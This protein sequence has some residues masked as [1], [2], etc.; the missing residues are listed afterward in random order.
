MQK[1]GDFIQLIKTSGGYNAIEYQNGGA[2]V[3]IS[4]ETL[5]RWTSEYVNLYSNGEEVIKVDWESDKPFFMYST[6]VSCNLQKCYIR[7]QELQT[8]PGTYTIQSGITSFHP[9]STFNKSVKLSKLFNDKEKIGNELYREEGSS[10]LY[11]SLG[12]INYIYLNIAFLSQ[13]MVQESNNES[14]EVSIRR[15]LQAIC[16]GVNKALGSINDLQVISDT[17]GIAETLTIIDYEQKRI[18]GLTSCKNIAKLQAQGLGSM[19]TGIQAQSS[20]TPEIATMISIG[21]QAQGRAL[22]VEATSFSKLNTGLTDNLYP[23]KAVSRTLD[24]QLKEQKEL[25]EEEKRIEDEYSNSLKAYV[26]VVTN[27]RPKKDTGFNDPVLLKSTDREDVENTATDLYKACLA[28]FTETGQTSTALIPIKLDLTLYGMSGMKIFQKFKLSND[29]LPLSYRGDFEFI[30][31][32]I[33]HEINNS[34][35]STSI[36]SIISLAEQNEVRTKN[37]K[38]FSVKLPELTPPITTRIQIAGNLSEDPAPAINPGRIGSQTP[39]FSPVAKDLIAQGY[40]NALLPFAPVPV[41]EFIEE[42]RGA[43]DYYINPATGKPGY[44][45]HPAAAAAWKKAKAELDSKNIP[46]QVY[47]AYRDLEH[48]SG[49]SKKAN[50]GPTVAKGGTS[51][52]GWG[53]AIDLRPLRNLITTSPAGNLKANLE[54]RK[55]QTYVDIATVLAKYNWYNPWRLSDNA[56]TVDEVW[57]FEYWG[58]AETFNQYV[59]QF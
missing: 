51:A 19:L 49:L 1:F 24:Q 8:T 36:S 7:N 50:G 57:H 58:S 21:A 37:G 56:G 29:I 59:P 55:T 15:Y 48:Q 26:K 10:R 43:R 52:H 27:Q 47:S 53:M 9:I 30:I 22:G 54:A 31:T 34:T 42:T 38:P 20:I 39:Q 46:V 17:D 14:G 16:D 44:A 3:Y 25:K 18:E 35:W 12:N 41:L 11:P 28:K 2:E 4:F 5:L 33:S 23:T 32:G 6:S 45:L 13:I 40:K